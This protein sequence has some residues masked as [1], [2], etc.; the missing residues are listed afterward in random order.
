VTSDQAAAIAGYRPVLPTDLPPG[1]E[2]TEVTAAA[3]GRPT[4][5]EGGNPPAAGVVSVAYRRGFDQI[6]VSTRMT[7]ELDTCGPQSTSACWYDPL[8]SGEGF[9][10]APEA[11]VVGGGALAGA[12]AELLV[13]ARGTPHC[14]RSTTDWW[15][16]SVV[17]LPARS[18]GAW[19][20][21]SRPDRRGR[22]MSKFCWYC[23]KTFATISA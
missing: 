4:G 22:Q 1:F 23:S 10:D 21:P 9:L 7:G 2:P 8:A 15:S 12:K 11:F 6:V 18:S 13:S 5:T 17:T 19:P 14:G 20:S 3:Q 16:R